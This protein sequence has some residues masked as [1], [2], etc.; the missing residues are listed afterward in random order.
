VRTRPACKCKGRVEAEGE[1]PLAGASRDPSSA[2]QDGRLTDPAIGCA[3]FPR[4]EFAS[5]VHP[6]SR[7]SGASPLVLGAP[8]PSTRAHQRADGKT[9]P[10]RSG[11]RRGHVQ[12]RAPGPGGAAVVRPPGRRREHPRGGLPTARDA[13]RALPRARPPRVRKERSAKRGP[14]WGSERRAELKRT[15]GWKADA[16]LQAWLAAQDWASAR[17]WSGAF[18]SGTRGRWTPAASS[19]A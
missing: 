7:S 4:C 14:D 1:R 3:R 11:R 17:P 12:G 8:P 10:R 2:G 16:T 5:E 9:E 19:G 13:P 15:G 6:E 18:S